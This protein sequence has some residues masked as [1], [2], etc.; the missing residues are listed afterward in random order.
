MNLL[1]EIAQELERSNMIEMH[2]YLHHIMVFIQSPEGKL[3][4]GV[5]FLLLTICLLPIDHD[6]DGTA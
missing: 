1:E 6:P 5:L 3:L 4:V 2:S